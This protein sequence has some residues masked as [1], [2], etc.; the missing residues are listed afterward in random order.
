MA[1]IGLCAGAAAQYLTPGND[2]GNL[3]DAKGVFITILIGIVGSFIGGFIGRLI[4]LN[5]SG[6]LGEI[7]LAIVGSLV[8]LWGYKKLRAQ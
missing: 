8:F 5:A 1:I 7:I 6:F 4:G 2:P 3:N